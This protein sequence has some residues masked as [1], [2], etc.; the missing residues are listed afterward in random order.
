[1]KPG[2]KT[3]EFWLTVVA[4]ILGLAAA[5]G[6]FTPESSVG[7]LIGL[8]VSVLA[9]LGYQYSRGVAKAGGQ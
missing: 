9:T 4:Q 6:A 3:S 2:Y 1:M 8:G 5:S 7:K